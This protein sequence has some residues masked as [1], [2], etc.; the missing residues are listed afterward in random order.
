VSLQES[1]LDNI[2][3]ISRIADNDGWTPLHF[4]A[5][6]FDNDV[7]AKMLLNKDRNVAYMKNTK[8]RTALHI[9][10]RQGKS[11][12]V[13]LIVS[14]CPD[15]CELVDYKGCNVLHFAFKRRRLSKLVIKVI[16][17]NSSLNNLL[18][19]ENDDG[20]TPLHYY[21]NSVGL[22]KNFVDDPRVDKMAFNKKNLSAWDIAMANIEKFRGQKVTHNFILHLKKN[23]SIIIYLSVFQV[24]KWGHLTCVLSKTKLPFQPII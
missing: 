5:Y 18:N 24:S 19:E 3:G 23:I 1:I 8:G 7:L 21:L 2:E 20:D 16:L 12:I 14:R 11:A 6:L 17:E 9:A 15:C 22:A 13:S 10:A 4:A